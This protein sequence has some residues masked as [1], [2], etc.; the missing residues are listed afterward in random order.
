MNYFQDVI[1]I[2]TS[3]GNPN[4]LIFNHFLVSFTLVVLLH[5]FSRQRHPI[6]LIS[7]VL[8][9]TPLSHDYIQQGAYNSAARLI[10]YV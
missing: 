5:T 9:M 6:P 4:R 7:H 2:R 3:Q 10:S 8:L 1:G